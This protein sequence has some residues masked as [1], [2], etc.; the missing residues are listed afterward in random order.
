MPRDKKK[1]KFL[2]NVDQNKKIQGREI[3]RYQ[4]SMNINEKSIPD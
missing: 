1:P 4:E 3:E 2:S